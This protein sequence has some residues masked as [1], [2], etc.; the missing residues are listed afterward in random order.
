MDLLDGGGGGGGGGG[1]RDNNITSTIRITMYKKA[2]HNWT[3]RQ[4]AILLSAL[5]RSVAAYASNITPNSTSHE[6]L[7]GAL[8]HAREREDAS[9]SDPHAAEWRGLSVVD[10]AV[11]F[12]IAELTDGLS[13]D[14]IERIYDK[15]GAIGTERFPI[16]RI[17]VDTDALENLGNFYFV[18]RRCRCCS[19]TVVDVRRCCCRCRDDQR[20]DV[21]H[22]RF[23]RFVRR[24]TAAVSVGLRRGTRAIAFADD[25]DRIPCRIRCRAR[26]PAT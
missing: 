24:S 17:A 15:I 20:R 13:D 23:D 19:F 6:I 4:C 5:Q 16:E 21:R 22:L 1:R 18:L 25:C 3:Q 14:E 2:T 8:R 10:L 12:G 9:L 7:V 11:A 26:A